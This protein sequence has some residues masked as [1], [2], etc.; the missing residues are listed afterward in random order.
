MQ[1]SLSPA[2]RCA[3]SLLALLVVLAACTGFS[4]GHASTAAPAGA[5]TGAVSR[6]NVLIV[7]TDDQ[8]I[9][10]MDVM[11]STL[12]RFA[13]QG[14]TFEHAFATTPLC[15][16]S[17]ASI[18]SGRYAHNH[19][20]QSNQPGAERDFDQSATIQTYLHDAGY[21]TAIFGK[22]FNAW[23]LSEDPPSFDRWAIESPNGYTGYYG[24][25]WNVDGTLHT[26][27]TYSTDYI[28]D[29]GVRFIRSGEAHDDQPWFLELA[30][31]ASHMPAYPA[32]R[33]RNAPVPPLQLD[34]SMRERDLRDK[35]PY[36]QG[37]RRERVET[38]LG[39]RTSQLRT[40]MS[41][42][43]LVRRVFQT[44]KANGETRETLAFFMGDNGML[45]G[46]HGISG[47]QTP[48]T[49]SIRLPM[50]ARWP[51]HIDAGA[52]DHR[53]VANIDVAPTV[54]AAA[55][56]QPS[57]TMDG[58]SLLDRWTRPGLLLEYWRLKHPPDV[59]TWASIRTRTF[60]YIEYYADNG[61]V[62]FRE[63]YD[64]AK[65][66]WQLTNLLR[67][68]KPGNDP[69]L[70]PLE[71]ELAAARTCVGTACP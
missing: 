25:T 45:W 3:P 12:R 28:A 27:D 36:V 55:A 5:A 8:R 57:G 13:D 62:T 61:S 31:Y 4:A 1:H 7:L 22:Y 38:I 39:T 6:P 24:G 32:A 54:L 59:P 63:Y 23:D 29:R 64:L 11:P 16:P 65:D 19:T 66:P 40:L 71:A 9:G 48:Y 18:F 20:V 15:C 53:F 43:D 46:A 2:N 26:I 17:R 42:D 33:Y 68:G 67:D 69:D 10:T 60:Q 51:G 14:T 70:G 52:V 58:R 34:P 37:R 41:V 50:F 21:R 35:P 44:L 30:T 56:I 47:K 49:P